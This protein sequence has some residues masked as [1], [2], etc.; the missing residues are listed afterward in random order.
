MSTLMIEEP[1]L[2]DAAQ[3]TKIQIRDR[4]AYECQGIILK[5]D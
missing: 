5:V 1:N 2:C 4:L 3:D